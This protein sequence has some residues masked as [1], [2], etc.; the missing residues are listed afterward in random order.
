MNT[1]E[2]LRYES[3]AENWDQALP[4]GN[5]RLGAMVFGNPLYERLQL[6][7]DSIWSGGKRNRNNGSA[8]ENLEKVRKL[9]LDEK[10]PEAEEI[11]NDAFCGTPSNQRHYMP[12]GNL[13][14]AAING[15]AAENYSRSLDLANSVCVTKYTSGGVN[16]TREVIAS[17]PDEAII[18]NIKGDKPAS[19]N[20]RLNIEDGRD[21]YYDFNAP[22]NDRTISYYGGMGGEDGINFACAV[23]VSVTGGASR[24]Y[25]SFLMCENCDEVTVAVCCRTDYRHKDYK[26]MC[27]KDCEKALS[28]PYSQLKGRHIADYKSFYD[29]CN[30][31]LCDNSGGSSALSTDRRL[32]NV[33][34]GGFDN[35][36]MELYFNFGRYLMISGSREGTLPLNLQGIWNEN[37]WPAW[38]CKFTINI[39][40]EMNYWPVEICALSE[41]HKPLFDIIEKMRPSGRETAKVM[42]NCGGFV[43][44][45]NTDLWGDTAPQ[46]LWMP[47]TQWPMGAAWLC[48]HIW[49]HYKFT[50][51]K[52]FLAEKFETLKEAAEFFVD[53]LIE[54]KKGRL[55]TCPSVSPENTYLTES[56]TKGSI[57]AGPSMDSQI[58][59]ELFTAV[60]ESGEILGKDED[61][62]EK[63]R[64]MRSRLPEIEI[65][66]YGQ[67]KEWA[68]DYDEVEPGHRHISQLFAL[69]PS[70]MISTRKTPELA[71]A[72]RATLD[73]RLSHG[74]GHTGWSRAWIINHWARLF[75]GEKVYENIV[76]L[77]SNSTSVNM[78]DMHPPFQID[79]NF[80]GTA[81]IAEALLQSENGEIVLLPALPEKWENGSFNG[82]KARGGFTVSAKWKSGKLSFA[83]IISDCGNICRIASDGLLDV[84]CCGKAVKAEY[85][86]GSTVFETNKGCEYEIG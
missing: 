16:Y 11:I 2:I 74:G 75:D 27:L 15:E 82:L 24:A 79:G 72:A 29:R 14:I 46:D 47:A 58:I 20:L 30:I 61:F 28:M 60:I 70:D 44:H 83:K 32:E 59:Y 36:L 80:G 76:A 48:L 26:E 57:C 71:K 66:K 63:L 7:E 73:R 86:D 52:T 6:N 53:F 31:D 78:F 41:L 85:A 64:E 43:C 4:V 56:G 81:G 23:S 9:I 19:V 42:Y 17:N 5:G 35:K 65:G 50:C 51:D 34:N 8:L 38:G 84:R 49:E 77:L 33:N 62:C 13:M 22:I 55:V 37:M 69:Y 45:H 40:T 54:D 67:I 10:I 12:L 3:P 25:G 1:S 21:D 18:I 39:N 68:E